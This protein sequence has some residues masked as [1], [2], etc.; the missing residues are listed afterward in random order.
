MKLH[1]I[2]LNSYTIF[3]CSRYIHGYDKESRRRPTDFTRTRRGAHGPF[4]VSEPNIVNVNSAKRFLFKHV[5][6]WPNNRNFRFSMRY[7]T[8]SKPWYDSGWFYTF[9]FFIYS[10]VRFPFCYIPKVSEVLQWIRRENK[11]TQN[12]RLF[13]PPTAG[14]V[15]VCVYKLQ[16]LQR[17]ALFDNLQVI[18]T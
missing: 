14:A 11:S 1:R 15:T 5:K 16:C 3:S 10:K 7:F 18:L 17:H 9:Q 8:F 13:T 2:A 4:W 12:P 6:N